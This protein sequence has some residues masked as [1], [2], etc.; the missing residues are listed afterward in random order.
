M[1]SKLDIFLRKGCSFF[2]FVHVVL[3]ISLVTM[4]KKITSVGLSYKDAILFP[5]IYY[6]FDV[7]YVKSNIISCE[8]SGVKL[9]GNAVKKARGSLSLRNLKVDVLTVQRRHSRLSVS[10]F[11]RSLKLK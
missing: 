1:G 4:R 11:V 2:Y 3:L 8:F 10:P 7:V 5:K 6:V 9:G